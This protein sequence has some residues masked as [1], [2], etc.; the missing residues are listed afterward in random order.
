MEE[1]KMSSSD[2]KKLVQIYDKLDE[3]DSKLFNMSDKYPENI[4]SGDIR[5]GIILSMEKI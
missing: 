3:I 2:F 1:K 4:F 5:D